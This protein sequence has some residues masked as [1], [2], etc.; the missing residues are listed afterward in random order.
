M[1]TVI[2]MNSKPSWVRLPEGK[3]ETYEDYG[4]ESLEGWHKKE[5]LYVE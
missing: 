5:G 2:K 1:Q 3:K 4:S